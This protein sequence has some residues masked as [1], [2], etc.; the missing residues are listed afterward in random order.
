MRR[1]LPWGLGLV[2]ALVVAGVGLFSWAKGRELAI[3]GWLRAG[4]ETRVAE[5]ASGAVFQFGDM[6]MVLDEG[7]RPR[8]LLRDFRMSGADGQELLAVSEVRASLA[9]RPLLRQEFELKSLDV[10]GVFLTLRRGANG[11][12]TLSSAGAAP[13]GES[14]GVAQLVT[15]LTDALTRPGLRALQRASLR[16][17]TLRYEDVPSDRAWTADGGRIRLIRQG[18][19]VQLSADLAVLG[20]GAGA[21]TIAANY[22]GRIG[23]LGS[24]FGVNISDVEAADIATQGPAFAW[25]DPLRAG[26]S[27]ALRGGVD[28]TGALT[29]LSV[30]LQISEGV[31]QPNPQAKP[32]PIDG[33]R[34]YFSYV[35]SEGLLSF[36]ELSVQSPWIS[37]RLEGQT[38]LVGGSAGQ[39]LEMVG[40]FDL[41]DL[42]ANPRDLFATPARIDRAQMDVRLRLD[43]FE[44]TIGQFTITDQGT[45]LAVQGD[46]GARSDGWAVR[47]NGGIDRLSHQRLLSFWPQGAAQKARNWL[48]QN[49][50]HADLEN[51]E[52]AWHAEPGQRP[53]PYLAF[54]FRNAQ[55]KFLP[56]IPSLR[57]G[58]GHA[59]LLRDRFVLTVDRGYVQA[60]KGG[61]V[62]LAGSS[63]ILPDLT[64]KDPPFG[65]VRLQASSSVTAALALLNLP[66]RPLL[67]EAK[68]PVTLAEG[69]VDLGGTIAFPVQKKP[70]PGSV[71]FD[72]A[73][74]IRDVHS[75]VLVP[76]HVL[77]AKQLDL[78]VANDE[79]TIS[80]QGTVERHTVSGRMVAAAG[81]GRDIAKPDQR[82]NCPFG[83]KP[84]TV[85]HP[86]AA[87]PA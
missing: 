9:M 65:I 58:Q 23:A 22:T 21:A 16:A 87:R 38:F 53:K 74:A 78:T 36:D 72:L 25:L 76:G 27:G 64:V 1:V 83:S 66:P 80:G 61:W 12:V 73:G 2:L 68:L 60:P 62:S 32:I 54:D 30:T 19:A 7:W 85:R 51:I 35:P 4:I 70:P 34:T 31:I 20:G 79:I 8:V 42:E 40:Q 59:S 77:R 28:E 14:S 26:I 13:L 57:Q 46:L 84:D 43:P 56:K 82:H 50:S 5:N 48:M 33:A 44:L 75:D 45:T 17:L 39:P 63:Y 29:P 11:A 55:A 24:E 47:L 37:G 18:D 86:G 3:P 69:T 49:L 67:D 15:D 41:A 10:Q 52:F 71:Q 81:T 6:F